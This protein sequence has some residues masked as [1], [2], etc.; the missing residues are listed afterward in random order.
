M[1][2]PARPFAVRAL[3]VSSLLSSILS[4][5]SADRVIADILSCDNVGPLARVTVSPAQVTLRSG[6]SVS[7]SSSQLDARGRDRYFCSTATL[8]WS[9]ADSSVA[10]VSVSGISQMIHA[11]NPGTTTIRA[12]VSSFVG[13]S[14][15]T[16]TPR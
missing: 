13:A 14:T 3:L 10:S 5:C 8:I 12:A 7:V 4:A 11:R 6:D 9:S 15:V 1:P 2:P 16:V